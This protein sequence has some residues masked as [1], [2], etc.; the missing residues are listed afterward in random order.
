GSVHDS[1]LV[2]PLEYFFDSSAHLAL[3]IKKSLFSV[4]KRGFDIYIDTYIFTISFLVSQDSIK[5]LLI[6]FVYYFKFHAKCQ[7]SFSICN[8]VFLKSSGCSI[9]KHSL[10]FV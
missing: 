5:G 4:R 8:N 7:D 2:Y 9:S 3:T 10:S 1:L 6:N